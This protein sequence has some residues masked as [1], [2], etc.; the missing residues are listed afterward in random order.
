LTKDDRVV[1]GGIMGAI[2][3]QKVDAVLRPPAAKN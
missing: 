2:P 1:I 3:G